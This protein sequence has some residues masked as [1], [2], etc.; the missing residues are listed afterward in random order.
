MEYRKMK[1]T[2]DAKAIRLAC[3][4]NLITRAEAQAATGGPA[5]PRRTRNLQTPT[6][7]MTEK[8]NMYPPLTAFTLWAHAYTPNAY[9]GVYDT[10]YIWYRDFSRLPAL[11]ESTTN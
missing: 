3:L 4:R 5:H 7:P 1:L 2:A 6:K 10:L 8:P 9:R 11:P